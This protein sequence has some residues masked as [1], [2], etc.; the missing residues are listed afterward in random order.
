[1]PITDDIV[2]LAV[3]PEKLQELMN[4]V[5]STVGDFNLHVRWAY[6]I[7]LITTPP[8]S[9]HFLNYSKTYPDIPSTSRRQRIH[10]G[11]SYLS[12]EHKQ[13]WDIRHIGLYSLYKPCSRYTRYVWAGI[14]ALA[15]HVACI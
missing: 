15:R 8:N 4:G 5:E 9:T 13:T 12:S 2:L 6:Q 3:S 14:I 10:S 1:M 7:P 11:F